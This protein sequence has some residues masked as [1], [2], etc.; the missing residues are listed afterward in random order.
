[1]RYRECHH[2]R[3]VQMD[4]ADS[5]DLLSWFS[6]IIFYT[7][8]LSE[9]EHIRFSACNCI[10]KGWDKTDYQ[11]MVTIRLKLFLHFFGIL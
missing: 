8:V 7:F 11:T 1:M 10:Q 4:W 3:A 5:F 9:D 6:A 2:G